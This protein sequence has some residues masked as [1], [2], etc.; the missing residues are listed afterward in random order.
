[1]TQFTQPAA[2]KRFLY[3]SP[4]ELWTNPVEQSPSQGADSC[5]DGQEIP[6]FMETK[7]SLPCSQEPTTGPYH[8]PLESSSHLHNL[9][10]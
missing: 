4:D 6:R 1:M 5:S 3:T 8:E 10:V 2:D 7:C 9:I